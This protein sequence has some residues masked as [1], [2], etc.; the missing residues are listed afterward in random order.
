MGLC[1]GRRQPAS[2]PPARAS[3]VQPRRV[4]G[5]SCRLPLELATARWRED[6]GDR[7]GSWG[8]GTLASA[9]ADGSRCPVS[10]PAKSAPLVGRPDSLG[11]PSPNFRRASAPAFFFSI[12]NRWREIS[13]AS[14]NRVIA[15]SGNCTIERSIPSAP[16]Q[17]SLS[18]SS[19]QA[20]ANRIT[21]GP[22][23]TVAALAA[24]AGFIF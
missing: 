7:G 6:A 9:L 11:V 5:R 23:K 22:L 14:S 13:L 19:G 24:L 16:S 3:H 21:T 2:R 20:L 1:T 17:I 12:S 15:E 4:S 10:H 8:A 18:T